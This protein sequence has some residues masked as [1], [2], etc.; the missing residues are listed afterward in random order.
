MS[1]MPLVSIALLVVAVSSASSATAPRIDT[2]GP[3]EGV[4]TLTLEELW[5]VGGED[6]EVLFGRITDVDRSSDGEV[7]V[8]DNQLCQLEVFG[9]DGAHLRTLSR[10]GDG[11]GEVRQPTACVLLP[12]GMVGIGAGFP[13]R[14]VT[15]QRDGTPVAIRHPIGVPAEGKIGVMISLDVGGGVLAATGGRIVFDTPETSYTERFLAVGDAGGEE[16]TRILERR[17]PIDPTGRLWDE[18]ADYYFDNRWDLGPDG[19]IYVP[20]ER[21]RYVVSVYDRHGTLLSAFGRDLEPRRRTDADKRRARPVIN[22]NG[23]RSVDTWEVCD[24]DPSIERIMVNP[25]DGTVWVLTPNGADEQPD[26]VLETWDVFA[27][28]GE[29]LRRA[30]V[31]LGHEIRD[32]TGY[33][34]GDGL[35]IVVRGAGISLAEDPEADAGTE[36]AEPQE[37]ICY[38]ITGTHR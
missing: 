8:L 10:Q 15:L 18:R 3:A 28:D 1:R 21:D 35:M 32:G 24:R 4:V 17:T 33:L 29:F 20:M 26:G 25:D 19:R 14:M 37:V 6:G 38:R 23:G 12:D 9:P 13:G 11:P 34:V 30:A 36:E 22:V 7:Y 27:P 5:R 16:F 31:P 2:D